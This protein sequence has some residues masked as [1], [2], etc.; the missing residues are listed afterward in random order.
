[1]A[2]SLANELAGQ[3]H[4]GGQ[5]EHIQSLTRQLH[6][7]D[8]GRLVA[9]DLWGRHGPH[10]AGPLYAGLDAI[11]FTDYQGWYENPGATGAALRNLIST[12]VANLRS[13]FPDK[14]LVVT[15]FGAAANTKNPADALGGASYQS[16]VLA[17]HIDTYRAL[18]DVSG[19]LIWSLRDYAL[20][21]AFTGG[22]FARIASGVTLTA[23]LNEKGVFDYA[24]R[25]KPAVAVVRRAFRGSPGA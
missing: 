17:Q 13:I 2:W 24:G 22:S 7:L 21:P 3:G 19:M 18:P 8:P 10:Y 6:E 20:T 5:P 4:P 15:E 25:A 1:V 14:V 9:V 12:R 16:D 23:G 11:G